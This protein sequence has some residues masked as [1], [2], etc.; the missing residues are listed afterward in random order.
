MPIS[1]RKIAET[2]VPMI[3]AD[4]VEPVELGLQRGGRGGDAGCRQDHH[5]RMAE[6]E[7]EADGEGLLA[8]LHQFADD[9]VDR[10]DVV[11]VDRVTEAEHVG[12]KGGAQEHRVPGEHRPGAEPGD[13]VGGDEH[14]VESDRP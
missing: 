4:L 9:I 1:S 2:A 12:E 8:L 14:R 7:K 11:G 3:P 10:R 13:D 6:G 5:R